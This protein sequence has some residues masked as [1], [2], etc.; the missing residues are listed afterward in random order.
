MIVKM[1]K[2]AFLVHHEDFPNFLEDVQ[3]IG[4]LDITTEKRSMNEEEKALL[5]LASRYNV[6]IKALLRKKEGL[7]QLTNQMPQDVLERFEAIVKDREAL[8]SDL[9]KLRKEHAE[10]YPWGDFN[11]EAIKDLESK[12]LKVKFFTTPSKRYDLEWEN[13]FPLQVINEQNGVIYFVCIQPEGE[14]FAIPATEVKAPV[15]ASSTLSKDIAAVNSKIESLE[16]E[17]AGL[18]HYVDMLSKA[19]AELLE[20]IDIKSIF[21]GAKREVEGSVVLVT[22]F[23]PHDS[24]GELNAYLESKSIVYLTEEATEQDNPPIKLKNGKFASL[25]EWIGEL[26]VPP[27]YNELDLTAFF[28]PFFVLFFGLCM[29]DI[30]YGFVFLIAGLLLKNRTSLSKFRPFLILMMWLGAGT[31][32]MGSLSGGVFGTEMA[33]W[34]FLPQNIQK[35]FLNRNQM[36]LFAVGIGFV[37][38]LFGLSLKAYNRAN[39]NGNWKFALGPIAWIIILLGAAASFVD[40][41]KPFTWHIILTG[42]G[43]LLL[44]GNPD[45]NIFARVGLGMAELY[46]I[47]GFFGDLLSY[48]RLFALGLSGS[49]LGLVVNQIAALTLGSLPFGLDYVIFGL[50]LVLGHG[51]N[52]ALASLGSFVHP[53]RLTFVEFY[54]NSGFEGNGRYYRPFAKKVKQ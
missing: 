53:L 34:P 28:A 48:I 31:I 42:V 38:I 26:Y 49:I 4:V 50:V 19:R 11:P 32:I 30:G 23:A 44:F 22:G 35:L 3:R 17:L 16:E 41:I 5:D 27:S 21:Y 40:P 47:T 46:D 9:K 43:I 6:A 1:Q 12:G 45:K 20:N 54:K 51:A 37:Q 24:I 7:E 18:S 14:N 2:Y 13:K 10:H 15:H 33:T 8:D 39:K 52:I 25:F 29:G 36:M